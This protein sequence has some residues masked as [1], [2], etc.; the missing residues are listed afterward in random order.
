MLEAMKSMTDKAYDVLRTEHQPLRAIFAPQSV[1]VIGATD[2]IGSVGRTVMWNLVSNSFGGTVFPVNPKRHS[3]L[4]IKTYP[5]IGSVPEPVDLAIIV[6]P[7][8][9]VPDVISE[10]VDAGVKGA[11]IISAGFKEA[12][13]TGAAL[14]RQ[15]LERARQG[16]LRM[17]GPNC[18][19]VM[20]PVTGLNATFAGAMARPG[21]VGFISQSGALCTAILDWS[22]RE[23]VGFSAFVSVGSMLDVGWGDLIDYLG[24]DPHTHSIVIYMESITHARS[25]LSAAREVALTKPIIVI[26]AGRTDAAAK[27]ATSHTGALAGSDA[28]LNAAF[29]RCGVLRVN[30]ISDL[31]DMA[32][33]LAKQPRPKGARLAIL[34]NA[35]GPGVLATDAL[36]TAGGELAELSQDTIAA[37]NQFLPPHWSHGNPI[38]ILGDADPQRYAKALEVAVQDPNSDGLLVILTPQAMTDPTQTA[39]Q[40]K[41]YV[42]TT[43]ESRHAVLPQHKP[44]LA[45]WMGGGSIAADEAILNR[46][47][48]PTYPY[49][50]AAARVF[51]YMWRY[52]YNLRGIY[53]TPILDGHSEIEPPDRAFVE[54]IL[55]TARQSGRTLL[56]EVESK[57]ILEAYGIPVVCT[58]VAQSEEEAAHYADEIGYPV[59]LKLLSQTITH[60]SD[61]GGVQLNLMD[62][63]AVR[64]AYRSIEAAVATLAEAASPSPNAF[65]GV[66]VQPMIKLDGYELIVGSSL[67]HQFGPVVLFGSGG[68]LVEVYEDRAIALPPLN[69]TLARRMMEQTR[70][71]RA[72]KGVRGR[73]PVDLPALEQLLVRF[74]QLVVEQRWIKEIDINPLLV[75]SQDPGASNG[76]I[77]EAN[78]SDLE[79]SHPITPHPTPP[80]LAL[81][82]RIVLH[83]LDVRQEQLPK[84]AIRPYPTQYVS[85]WTLRDNS[86]VTIRPIRPEDEPLMIQFHKTLS[87]QSV[88]FRYFH[89][90]KLSQRTAHDRLTRICFIDYD[91]EMALV[92]DYKSPETGL[93]EILAVAR[94][95]KLHG[96]NE[97]EFA[98]LVSDRYQCQGLG[99]KLL[100]QLLQAGQDEHLIRIS[101]E[102]LAENRAMQRVCEKLG[103]RL[104]PAADASV[105]RA[106]ID[107]SA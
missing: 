100:Q 102:I 90:M 30:D 27:A 39:E 29:H 50:D 63:D 68:Q 83:G 12:G 73:Q 14:E 79:A 60:K 91:R 105:V 18:L 4:G 10:C 25:F 66:T 31:F 5:T 104:Q 42:E 101:A 78:R 43:S 9:G 44:I 89:L 47:G 16:N 75:R 23:N 45:S 82:A 6:V 72:L 28:V 26:K 96:T 36:I 56:T 58:R 67:D 84:L 86:P 38:D 40:L 62:A 54:T 7:A 3:V 85:G 20:N 103:F 95:S 81:D 77:R 59:V 8:A 97:A 13:E 98:L 41:S 76:W 24:N 87:E 106:E 71:Y 48:I 65:L 19:G 11:I 93:H 1:A 61:I 34:T 57:Q 107:L 53:E 51:G 94:L 69:T 64:K 46:A 52:S 33:V 35:G 92:A 99:T 32:E 88:Y 17:V 49:P 15:I 37:L 21:N 22:L 80:L 74:S 2:R 55:Q 70:I